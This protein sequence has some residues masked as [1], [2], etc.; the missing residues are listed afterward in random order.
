LH[1]GRFTLKILNDAEIK[2]QYQIKFPNTFI[3]LENLVDNLGINR[4]QKM[5]TKDVRTPSHE[6]LWVESTQTTVS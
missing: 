1:T 2:K 3:V 5:I 6:L 4:A